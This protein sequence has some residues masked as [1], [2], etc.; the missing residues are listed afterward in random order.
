MDKGKE[1]ILRNSLSELEQVVER[2][3]D[4][5]PQN[6]IKVNFTMRGTLLLLLSIL[7]VITI[8]LLLLLI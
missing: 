8:P 4:S 3:L 1:V 2:D 6:V 7:C 5:A